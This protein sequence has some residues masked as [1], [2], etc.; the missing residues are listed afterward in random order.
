MNSVLWVAERRERGIWLTLGHAT[1]RRGACA[2]CDAH[3]ARGVP[4]P[5]NVWQPPEAR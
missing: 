5:Y 4:G 1:T 3:V 2:I